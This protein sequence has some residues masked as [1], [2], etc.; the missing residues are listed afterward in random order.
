MNNKFGLKKCGHGW[1]SDRYPDGGFLR[2]DLIAIE[3]TRD[4]HPEFDYE[5]VLDFLKWRYVGDCV[6]GVYRYTKEFTK[7]EAK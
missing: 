2:G 5:Q 4:D 6:N 7:L 1:R 3:Q